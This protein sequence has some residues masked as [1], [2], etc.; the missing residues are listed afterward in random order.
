[1]TKFYKWRSFLLFDLAGQRYI[2]DDGICL[3]VSKTSGIDIFMFEEDIKIARFILEV[4]GES[5][6]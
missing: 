5:L 3:R 1:M 2:I 6:S 4:C